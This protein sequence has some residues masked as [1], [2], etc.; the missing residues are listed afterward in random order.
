M[1]YKLPQILRQSTNDHVLITLSHLYD[2]Q[3]KKW[4]DPSAP[5]PEAPSVAVGA[6]AETAENTSAWH[7][8]AQCGAL[9]VS[10]AFCGQ[11]GAAPKVSSGTREEVVVTS[12]IE[13][14]EITR[15]NEEDFLRRGD[16]RFR[17]MH[18]WFLVYWIFWPVI[19]VFFILW[20]ILAMIFGMSVPLIARNRA[21]NSEHTNRAFPVFESFAHPLFLLAFLVSLCRV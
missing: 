8:C 9:Q 16:P 4:V 18:L 13:Q 10:G 1:T 3:E 20:M 17:S 12:T 15:P 21:L 2:S 14:G 6:T 19:L 7:P 11:C 5:P